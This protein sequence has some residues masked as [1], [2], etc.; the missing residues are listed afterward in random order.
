MQSAVASP[1]ASDAGRGQ[2]LILAVHRLW[3]IAAAAKICLES[4]PDAVSLAS[5][6]ER[7]GIARAEGSEL[8]SGP[9]E[10][11]RATFSKAVAVAAEYALPRFAGEPDP[12]EKSRLAT[13]HLLA[14]CAAEPELASVCLAD[15][16]ATREQRANLAGT[17]TWIV[18]D[19]F[20]EYPA[21]YRGDSALVR[22]VERV[23]HAVEEALHAPD[24]GRVERLYPDILTAILTPFVGDPAGRILA[25]RPAPCASPPERTAGP[26]GERLVLDLRLTAGLLAELM[27][28]DQ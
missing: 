27:E 10:L 5:V 25:T 21:R 16:P 9:A 13:A 7:S 26:D 23:M 8:F 18:A 11:L 3:M 14:F 6:A 4:G 20:E 15:C 12:L 17:L 19:W 24:P 1:G 28:L 2:Q 22:T